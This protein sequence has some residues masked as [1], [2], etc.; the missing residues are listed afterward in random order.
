MAG[1][2]RKNHAME[3]FHRCNEGAAKNPLQKKRAFFSADS[4]NATE[5]NTACHRHGT[6]SSSSP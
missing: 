1:I 6:M 4:V 2:E 5:R 3:K